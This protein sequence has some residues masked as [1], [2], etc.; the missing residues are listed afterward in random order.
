MHKIG[1]ATAKAFGVN[2]DAFFECP[3]E[4]NYGCPHGFFEQ[5]LIEAPDAKQAALNVCDPERMKDKPRKFYF[6]C[7]HG[8]GHGV[9]MAK[10]YDVKQS[11]DVCD[12]FETASQQAG[13]WQGVFMENTNG[14]GTTNMRAN[15]FSKDDPL[16]PCDSL[17]DK[18]LWECYLN[19]A[20]Y[21]IN[22]M[23]PDARA[24]QVSAA[25]L[26]AKEQGRTAC[27]QGI[28]L[29]STNADWQLR[30]VR[31]DT[32]DL[33]KN[34]VSICD[35]FPRDFRN[36]CFTAGVDNL[37][38]F[39]RTDI[40]RMVAFC[41]LATAEFQHACYRQIGAATRNEI[42]DGDDGSS[43]CGGVPDGFRSDCRQGAGLSS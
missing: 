39:D 1:R 11:L 7:Y 13:C 35:D 16:Y 5:A 4:F 8:V 21:L 36:E 6:Y 2:A 24:A 33:L 28:G 10:A 27:L 14:Y 17:D 23:G 37:A 42:P 20:G 15:S 25:C 30:L 29:M 18:Y 9:M 26:P 12:G 43:L 3:L 22:R 41:A 34:A 31:Q 38:N 32:G 19:H 40:T